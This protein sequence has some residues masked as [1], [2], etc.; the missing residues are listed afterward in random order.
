[1]PG[2]YSPR[3]PP[4]QTTLKPLE[5]TGGCMPQPTFVLHVEPGMSI[6][7]LHS[8]MAQ[9]WGNL[10]FLPLPLERATLER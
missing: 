7:A 10:G 4:P 2:C 5:G 3:L 6:N 1:M 8:Q 9:D